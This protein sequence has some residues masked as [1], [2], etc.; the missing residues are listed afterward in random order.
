MYKIYKP[1]INSW[2]CIFAIISPDDPIDLFPHRNHSST[3]QPASK[4]KFQIW[5]IPVIVY[6]QS[7]IIFVDWEL[8]NKPKSPTGFGD[9]K[10][11]C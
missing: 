2:T 3:P 8:E 7:L 10:E 9:G 4:S 6:E 11:P 5:N 1:C